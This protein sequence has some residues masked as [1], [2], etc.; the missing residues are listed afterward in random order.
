[1]TSYIAYKN[2]SGKASGDNKTWRL[3]CEIFFEEKRILEKSAE[4]RLCSK[5]NGEIYGY[6]SKC[7]R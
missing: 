7:T 2:V 4:V 6:H 5:N 3:K 1:M